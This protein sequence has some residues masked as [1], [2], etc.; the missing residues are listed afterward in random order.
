[1]TKKW[2]LPTDLSKLLKSLQETQPKAGYPKYMKTLDDIGAY[3][4]KTSDILGA[5]QYVLR[6]ILNFKQDSSGKGIPFDLPYFDLYNRFVAGKKFIDK[7]FAKASVEMRLKYYYDFCQ[8]MKKTN[9][10][11]NHEPGFRKALRQLEYAYKW[12]N[13][14]RAIL[15]L[16]S[17][18][19]DDR[20]LA[21]LSKQYRLTSAEAEMLPKRLNVFL[22]SL[23]RELQR[24]KHP[25]RIA[26]LK[27]LRNQVEKYQGNLHVSILLV[28]ID[29][30]ETLLVPPRT[31]NHLERLF[32]FIKCL[33]RRCSGHSKLSKE[34]GSIG[35]LLP[36]YLMMRDH[37]LFRDVFNDDRIIAEEFA[38]LF[39][40][41]QQPPKNLIVLPQNS[42]TVADE[43][44]LA[45]IGV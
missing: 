44:Q 17:Q 22:I 1:M 24:C 21:P 36:Y 5:Y 31:N 32:R 10:L 19:K 2:K 35:A 26:F 8:V 15:F 38:K 39:G 16:Q 37:P 45:A 34:F 42:K 28:T 18:I 14:L 41:S 29:G 13:K 25:Y 30:K 33:L 4:E 20:T 9:K 7:I 11:G 23:K 6:W 27:K 40:K 43:K 12:F 3:M